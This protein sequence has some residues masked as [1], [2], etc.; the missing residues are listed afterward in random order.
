MKYNL[1]CIALTDFLLFSYNY[2]LPF[3]D[4]L[5]LLEIYILVRC[6]PQELSSFVL[7]DI[8]ILPT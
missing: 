4:G 6:S 1:C 2:S 5:L 8:S 3:A 7:F